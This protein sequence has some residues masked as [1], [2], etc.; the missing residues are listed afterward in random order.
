MDISDQNDALYY[1]YDMYQYGSARVSSNLLSCLLSYCVLPVLARSLL[2]PTS[3][4]P[5]LALYL[6]LLMLRI[7]K[8]KLLCCLIA[9]LLFGKRIHK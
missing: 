6:L 8:D 7:F 2:A 3:V 1:L 4:K 5:K 9:C